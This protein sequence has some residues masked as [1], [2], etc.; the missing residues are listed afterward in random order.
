M[1]IKDPITLVSY[2][3]MNHLPS[4]EEWNWVKEYASSHEEMKDMVKVF[5]ASSKSDAQIKFGIEVANGM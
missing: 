1:H 4:H 2:M 3:H 5:R